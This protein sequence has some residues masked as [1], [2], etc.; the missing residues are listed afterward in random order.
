MTLIVAIWLAV[1]F[2]SAFILACFVIRGA[3][4]GNNRLDRSNKLLKARIIQL[5]QRYPEI[6]EKEF[7][8]DWEDEPDD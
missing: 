4:Q 5:Q 6:P 1:G 7:Y 3:I 2:L 8:E